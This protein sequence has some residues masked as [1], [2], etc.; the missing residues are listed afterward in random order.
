M[1]ALLHGTFGEPSVT[2]NR[3]FGGSARLLATLPDAVEMPAP[4]G[5]RPVGVVWAIVVTAL[6]N[7]AAETN[8]LEI[9]AA[10]V[11]LKRAP[12]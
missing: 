3:T 12:A 9:V 4:V 6:L 1:L 7:V 2:T 11:P 10:V 8:P 5:V